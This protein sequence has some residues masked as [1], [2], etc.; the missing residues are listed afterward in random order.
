MMSMIRR[1]TE[2]MASVV[3]HYDQS[4][5]VLVRGVCLHPLPERHDGLVHGLDPGRIG[6]RVVIVVAGP[7]HLVKVGNEQAGGVL[8]HPGLYRLDDDGIISGSLG[9]VV[10]ADHKEVLGCQVGS[11]QRVVALG[12][13]AQV[14]RVSADHRALQRLLLR[15]TEDLEQGGHCGAEVASP[16]IGGEVRQGYSPACDQLSMSL[17]GDGHAAIVC[18]RYHRPLGE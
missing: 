17:G 2:S 5:L 16:V 11:A 4:G 7:V 10:R 6:L 14:P 9:G 3:C 13:A 15:L 12:E 1:C 18:S 8:I